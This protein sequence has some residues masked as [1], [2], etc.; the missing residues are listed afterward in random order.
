MGFRETL[1]QATGLQIFR[2]EG[3]LNLSAHL[4]GGIQQAVED[5][6]RRTWQAAR[7]ATVPVLLAFS[8]G[9]WIAPAAAQTPR[10]QYQ[11]PPFF[12][13]GGSGVPNVWIGNDPNS[14]T[15]SIYP[16]APIT[17]DFR[18]VFS[19]TLFSG[20]IPLESR[21]SRIVRRPAGDMTSVAG[22]EAAMA[23]GFSA[24]DGQGR[25]IEHVRIAIMSRGE[26]ALV[27]FAVQADRATNTTRTQQGFLAFLKSLSVASDAA[28]STGVAATDGASAPAHDRTAAAAVAI[29]TLR[30]QQPP[31]FCSVAAVAF[32]TSGSPAFRRATRA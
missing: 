24:I 26:V 23:L 6:M 8:S 11:P 9:N 12:C 17:G 14:G 18:D 10:L 30:Y 4:W 19:R 13:C 25:L 27:D 22:A 32:P 20:R 7:R 21:E 16:F 31:F 15:L 5:L 2:D 3:N 1:V 28:I 29:H